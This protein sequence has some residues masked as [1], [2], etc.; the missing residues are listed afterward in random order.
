[1]RSYQLNHNQIWL[2]R[3]YISINLNAL[4]VGVQSKAP[5]C[6]RNSYIYSHYLALD[7]LGCAIA[8]KMIRGT[9]QRNDHAMFDRLACFGQQKGRQENGI[10]QRATVMLYLYDQ[11]KWEQNLDEGG[12][13]HPTLMS[14][15]SSFCSAARIYDGL[16]WEMQFLWI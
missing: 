14:L 4:W 2:L 16:L 1:M 5:H 8:E 10:R 3:H 7:Y 11:A 6:D 13:V 9:A 12:I 15:R